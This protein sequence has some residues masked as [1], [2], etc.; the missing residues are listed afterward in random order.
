MIWPNA[1]THPMLSGRNEEGGSEDGGN[2]VGTWFR[3]TLL[4]GCLDLISITKAPG[5][6][7]SSTVGG[8]IDLT[9]AKGQPVKSPCAQHSS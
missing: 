3:L 1:Q 8:T 7:M 6:R 4:R 2:P 5:C 9:T